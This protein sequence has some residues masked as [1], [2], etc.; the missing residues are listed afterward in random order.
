VEKLNEHYGLQVLLPQTNQKPVGPKRSKPP[1]ANGLT[2]AEEA[3]LNGLISRFNNKEL[4]SI[5]E[6]ARMKDLKMKKN[7]Q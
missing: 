2:Q 5:Q 7:K 3:E 4:L 1:M 6:Q